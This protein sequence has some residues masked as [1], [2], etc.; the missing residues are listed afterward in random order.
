MV[1]KNHDHLKSVVNVPSLLA[2]LR[3]HLCIMGLSLGLHNAQGNEKLSAFSV[4]NSPGS[5][6]L[7]AIICG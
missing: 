6:P 7:H 3:L 5:R 4:F 1:K 2:H